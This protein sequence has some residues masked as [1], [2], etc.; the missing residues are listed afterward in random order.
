M[1]EHTPEEKSQEQELVEV[2]KALIAPYRARAR[3]KR[4]ATL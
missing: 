4:Y 3:W 1:S 2:L